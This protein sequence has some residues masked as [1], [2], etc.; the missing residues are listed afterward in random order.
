MNIVLI[1]YRGTGKST[2]GNALADKL[3]RPFLDTDQLIISEAKLTIP[4]I[5]EQEGEQGFRK[6]EKNVIR[7]IDEDRA[8]IACGG[9]AVMDPENGKMLRQNGYIF[10]LTAKPETILNRIANEDG[11]PPLTSLPPLEEIKTLLKQRA[12]LYEKFADYQISTEGKSINN[13][14]EEVIDHLL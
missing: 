4:E 1:G 2:L 14:L 10:W 9:G 5:F 11:R 6:R 8:V 7:S 12:P 3:D 13:L